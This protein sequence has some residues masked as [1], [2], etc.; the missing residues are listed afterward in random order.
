MPPSQVFLPESESP[1]IASRLESLETALPLAFPFALDIESTNLCNLDCFFCP[2]KEAAKGEGLMDIAIF[3]RIVDECALRGPIRKI[4]LHK[5]GEPLAHPQIVEMVRYIRDENAADVISFTSNGIL[6]KPNKAEELI[7]AGLNDVSF[8]IDATQSETYKESKGRD[9]YELVEENVRNFLRIKPAGVKVT[10]K[11]IR[12]RENAGEEQVFIEKWS[13][14]GADIL[15]TEYHDWSGSVRDSSLLGVDS[16]TASYAC[17][18]PWYSLAVNWDGKVSICCVDWD[19]Q[20]VVGDANLESIYEIWNGDALR[21]IRQTHLEGRAHCITP[22]STCT[23]KSAES[24]EVIG[25]WL[26]GE[27]DRLLQVNSEAAG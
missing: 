8:S 17:E 14:A 12:M 20:A 2:R 1:S 9:K 27:A 23:Y 13:D 3:K 25:G 24:R 10:V 5:D 22:C 19:S 4:G 18:N 11:F 7:E 6:M 21:Q 26:M 16:G 15:I